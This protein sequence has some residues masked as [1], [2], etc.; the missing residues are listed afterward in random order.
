MQEELTALE[1]TNTWKIMHLPPGK[2]PIDCKWVYKGI[3]FLDTFSPVAK[4]TTLKFLLALAAV[5][6][7]STGPKLVCKIN[8]SLY[9]LKQASRQWYLKLSEVLAKFGLQQSASDHSFFFKKDSSMFFGVVVYVDDMMIAMNKLDM[10]EA[11]KNFLSQVFKFKD[12]GVP[13][14]FL[15]LEIANEICDGSYQRCRPIRM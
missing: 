9:G 10:T 4:L 13:K 5:Y 12:L 8:K 14:Y 6:D 11:F 2:I 15:G 7:C 3:D 1:K